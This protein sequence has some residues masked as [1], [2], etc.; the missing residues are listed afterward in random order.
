M[1]L[2]LISPLPEIIC[3]GIRSI[4]AYVELHGI[5]TQIIFLPDPEFEKTGKENEEYHYNENILHNT[6]ELCPGSDLVGITLFSNNLVNAI[7]LTDFLKKSLPVPII[8]GGKHL[9]SDA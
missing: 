4:A 2:T 7:Q 3:F 9:I 6:A 5:E 8:W 1:K